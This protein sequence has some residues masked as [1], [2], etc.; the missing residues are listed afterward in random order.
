MPGQKSRWNP[1][2]TYPAKKPL[3]ILI[4]GNNQETLAKIANGLM[5]KI[6]PIPGLKNLDLSY[7][8]GAPEY[9]ILVDRK[10]AADLG[11]G[12]QE[13]AMTLR[14]LISE[15][16]ISTFRDE[17]NEYDIFVQLPENQRNSVKK[18]KS[19]KLA[20]PS[21][22]QVPLSEVAQVIPSF[23]PSSINRRD[24]SR[25]VSVQADTTGD[26]ALSEVMAK[27]IPILNKEP[28]PTGYNWIIAGEEQKRQEIFGDMFQALFLAIIMVYVFLAVQFESF[29]HPFTIMLSVPLE[30]GGLLGA[31]IITNTTMTMFTL[32]GVIMLVGIVV[33]AAIVLIDYIIQRKNTGLTTL[34][35]IREA[36]PLRLRPIMMTVGTTILAMFPLALGLK[37]GTEL[38]Q[39]L[40]IGSIGGLFTSSFL[41][42]LII[43]VVYS[44][45]EEMREKFSK[46]N[47]K[48]E[49]ES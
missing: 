18:I 44:L 16:E 45:L 20:T 24:R 29:L 36:A 31:L 1:C 32:L 47:N 49:S 43:P 48:I 19:L 9:R 39:P 38:Y 42:L 35:A 21:G 27:V 3:E 15:D 22:K 12:S 33:S 4:R 46:K 2:L 10:K 41:T 8:S 13:V 6:K 37:A 23:G 11:F 26:V 34:D 14:A 25:Y 40:A 28:M 7:R 17:G 30:L 5:E